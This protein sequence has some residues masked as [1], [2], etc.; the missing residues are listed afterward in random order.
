MPYSIG[1]PLATLIP[2]L[3]IGSFLAF[4]APYNTQAFGTPGVW[5]YWTGLIALGWGAGALAGVFFDWLKP[6]WPIWVIYLLVSLMVSVPVTSAVV[7]IQALTWGPFSLPYI[8]GVFFSVWVISAAVT[9]ISYLRDARTQKNADAPS[10]GTTLI[11]KLPHRLRQSEI[12]AL[13]SEDHYLRV[14]TRD[15]DALILMRL[16]DAIAAVE[17]LEG[18]QTHRSWWVARQ[19]VEGVERGNGRATLSLP[20][21]IEA[22]VSRTYAPKLREAGW[23]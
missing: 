19:A 23:Y 2:I 17:A 15:G 10:I 12:I 7:L 20:G 1:K 8:P 18:A 5:F 9:T 16:S 6:A 4:I 13:V 21:G 14:Y 22:P 11:E 3:A